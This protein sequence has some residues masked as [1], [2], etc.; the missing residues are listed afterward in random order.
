[1]NKKDKNGQKANKTQ[2]EN[3]MN[4]GANSEFLAKTDANDAES[5]AK[6]KNTKD[7]RPMCNGKRSDGMGC[8]NKAAKGST[9][10]RQR[11]SGGQST[12]IAGVNNPNY[13][14][15]GWTRHLP[16]ELLELALRAWDYPDL[17]S[18]REEIV[19]RK[20]RLGKLAS[21]LHRGG[22]PLD[23]WFK[24]QML[25]EKKNELDAQYSAVVEEEVRILREF[26][27]ADDNE[28]KKL[29]V[30]L[31]KA[32]TDRNRIRGKMDNNKEQITKTLK[33]A[34]DDRNI[35]N[36]IEKMIN[37]VAPLISQQMSIEEKMQQYVKVEQIALT[38]TRKIS[39]SGRRESTKIKI[40]DSSYEENIYGRA[41]R[42]NSAR[43]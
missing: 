40:G 23:L 9:K 24:F 12:A 33:I 4:N 5:L 13:K 25:N 34:C 35:E 2:T 14:G 18:V 7:K 41:D 28:R 26:I 36:E 21:K 3:D 17:F 39:P 1:M 20:M 16:E 19:Y 29:N 22:E 8:R 43:I 6:S 15:L 38:C 27:S 42:R 37:Q 32:I 11:H 30:K 10:C 31:G